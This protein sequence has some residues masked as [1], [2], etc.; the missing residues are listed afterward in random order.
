AL[1]RA[2]PQ[3]GVWLKHTSGHMCV[4]NSAVLADLDLDDVP[5]G[6][7]VVRDAAGR[8][9]GLLREQA[10]LLLQPLVF[11]VP[12][13]RLTRAI[14][15]ANKALTAQG[16]TS[17]QEAGIGGGWIGQTPIELAAYQIARAERVLDVRVT[18]MI[19]SDAMHAV[20]SAEDDDITF[21]VDLGLRTG[22]GDD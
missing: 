1:D 7:D 21:G 22:F 8:P 18:V 12:V 9:T 6:G 5:E 2:A 16:V 4:V 13:A 15:R 14:E 10:Q 11:P 17:V 20:R 19:A 3:H